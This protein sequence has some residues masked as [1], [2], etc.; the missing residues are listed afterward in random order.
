MIGALGICAAIAA[1]GMFWL[2]FRRLGLARVQSALGAWGLFFVFIWASTESLSLFHALGSLQISL[3]WAGLSLVLGLWLRIWKGPWIQNMG[4]GLSLEPLD[5]FEWMALIVMGLLAV[6]TLAVA[7][8]SPPNTWDSLSYHMPRVMHWAQNHSV[9]H[10]VTHIDR[11]LYLNPL[12][13][14]AILHSVLLSGGDRMANLP[15]W[16]SLWVAALAVYSLARSLGGTR[17]S[18]L[19]AA[20]F[21]FTLPMV[22]LQ[23]SSTQNDL[24]LTGFL[25]SLVALSLGPAGPRPWLLVPLTGLVLGC[26]WLTKGTAYFLCLPLVLASLA[27]G[28]AFTHARLKKGAVVVLLALCMNLPYWVRNIRTFG[29]PLGRPDS[30]RSELSFK[31]LFSNAVRN[32]A[33]EIA[34]PGIGQAWVYQGAAC[35]LEALGID[36]QDPASTWQ[37][38]AFQ[39]RSPFH[40]DSANAWMHLLLLGLVAGLAWK[41]GT[42]LSSRQAAYCIAVLLASG[43]FCLLRW[44][45]W[46]A[47]L[48]LPLFALAGPIFALALENKPRTWAWLCS[49]LMIGVGGWVMVMG[50][51]RSIAGSANVFQ[52][53][54]LMLYFN[55]VPAAAEELMPMMAELRKLSNPRLGFVCGE[56]DQEYLAWV[57]LGWK[58]RKDFLLEHLESPEAQMRFKPNFILVSSLVP[59]ASRAWFVDKKPLMAGRRWAL[60]EGQQNE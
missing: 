18:G 37:G 36:P 29:H 13:E 30:Y 12:A 8:A 47:R 31:A 7:L 26:A 16:L 11:Q 49:A 9:A 15:Q 40:E 22:L 38:Q 56:D 48:H 57:L 45:P 53:P 6:L 46:H 10:Y 4:H 59:E 27:V 58:G 23:S 34:P 32:I 17:A 55:N 43:F 60:F 39:P 1:Y 21:F 51:P 42:R 20:L 28:E 24:V 33:L 44:Q 5:I 14:Y 54:R 50:Q 25:C 3:A 35:G 19:L 41:N 52:Q 2:A